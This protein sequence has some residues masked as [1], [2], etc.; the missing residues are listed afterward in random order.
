MTF[1]CLLLDKSCFVAPGVDWIRILLEAAALLVDALVA[2]H[3]KSAASV[4]AGL[5][6]KWSRACGLC[7]EFPFSIRVFIPS[8]FEEF[9]PFRV[10]CT[11]FFQVTDLDFVEQCVIVSNCGAVDVRWSFEAVWAGEVN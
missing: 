2:V 10:V 8:A 1:V 5:S 6:R 4:S 11:H 7:F 9:G 3:D